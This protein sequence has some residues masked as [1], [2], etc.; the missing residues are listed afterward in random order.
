MIRDLI[1]PTNIMP[2]TEM[3]LS[4]FNMSLKLIDILSN[5]IYEAS[6]YTYKL[7]YV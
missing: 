2:K 1:K 7:K 6:R 4:D 3:I 5:F